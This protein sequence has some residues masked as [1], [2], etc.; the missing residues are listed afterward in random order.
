MFRLAYGRLAR[1]L[2]FQFSIF[3]S[4][5]LSS[6]MLRFLPAPLRGV[7]SV[8]FL[9]INTVVC[10]AVLLPLSFAKL[11]VPVAGVRR[12]IDPLL[13]GIALFW[14]RMNTWWMTVVAQIRWDVRGV[15]A[16][17]RDHWYLVT[18]NH[19]S[20]VDIFVL[21][22]VFAP[23]IPMLKFFLKQELIWVP[24]IGLAWWALDFPF[25]RRHSEAF[26]RQHPERR[27]DDL[28]AIRRACER[29]ALVPT[30][31][32]N[33]L[34]GT[35]FTPAKHARD[36]SGYKHLLRPKAGGIALALNAMGEQFH[37][38]LDVTI[39]YPEGAPTFF[40]FLSGRMSRVVVDVRERQ[41]AP[42][43]LG[44][45]YAA[46]PEFRARIQRWVGELWSEKDAL[47][48]S[49]VLGERTKDAA[50]GMTTSF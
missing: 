44:G 43:L 38:L 41:L 34:E 21:L 2:N 25:M 12:R 28:V 9:S 10:V 20:W 17:R 33:F 3:N 36:G 4:H 39:F 35:R 23:R 32:M 13:N 27:G 18:A 47:L 6:H 26:L 49:L 30:A 8:L 19:Q 48:E 15:G 40:E 16:L 31:V 24:V 29:F 22:K 37:V 5:K 50:T 46:D 11:V 1:F 42:E 45:N 14:S 7:L